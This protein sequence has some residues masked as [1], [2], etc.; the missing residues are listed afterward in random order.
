MKKII[1]NLIFKKLFTRIFLFV[2]FFVLFS[3]CQSKTDIGELQNSAETE[4]LDI[5]PTLTVAAPALFFD[6][7]NLIEQQFFYEIF[8]ESTLFFNSNEG[9]CSIRNQWNTKTIHYH[10]SQDTQADQAIRWYTN[11]FVKGWSQPEIQSQVNDLQ[12]ANADTPL[13]EYQEIANSIYILFDYREEMVFS[14]GEKS[15]WYTYPQA[16][17]SILDSSEGDIYVRI[18]SNG[19]FP[20]ESLDFSVEIAKKLY[21]KLP[22]KFMINYEFADLPD[23][24]LSTPTLPFLG[25]IPAIV[26]VSTDNK[27]IFFGDLCSNETTLIRVEIIETDNIDSIFLVYRLTSPSETNDHWISR[28]MLQVSSGI[29]ELT[30]SAEA[31]F[32][33]FQLVNG[34]TLEYAIS[35]LYGVD[36][37]LRSTNFND[38]N[39]FQCRAVD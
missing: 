34:A 32:S 19:F 1:Q 10:V 35:I 11:K 25:E 37:I 28:S 38:V 23:I 2:F 21:E 13:A 30:I 12:I 24:N 5:S 39:V 16:K 15:Y 8:E 4:P 36:G 27:S 14:V 18:Q 20:E 22:E 26:S 33:R 29:W 31:D 9:M 6:P 17:T 7:C 3:G